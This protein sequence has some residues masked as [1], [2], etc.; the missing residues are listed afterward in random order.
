MSSPHPTISSWERDVHEGHYQAEL[1]GFE[2]V[3]SWTPNT[4]EKRGS[5]IWSAARGDS[6][7]H[8]HH[9]FEEMELAMADAEHFAHAEAHKDT[10]AI[11]AVSE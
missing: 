5:F 6:T 8:G 7:H 9:G 3:V 11:A 2:L 10:L 1:H 4:S